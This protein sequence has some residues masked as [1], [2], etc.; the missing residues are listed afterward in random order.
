MAADPA[1]GVTAGVPQGWRK[2][3]RPEKPND[4]RSVELPSMRVA[5]LVI[6]QGGACDH[7]VILVRHVHADVSVHMPAKKATMPSLTVS[8]SSAVY[9]SRHTVQC[10]MLMYPLHSASLTFE[11]YLKQT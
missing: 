11:I 6:R 2:I 4:R 10:A 1:A 8:C 9:S 3:S 5:V 7:G